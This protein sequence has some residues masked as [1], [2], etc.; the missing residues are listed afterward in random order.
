MTVTFDETVF[1]IN[2]DTPRCCYSFPAIY[3][4]FNYGTA[5]P[6]DRLACKTCGT[7]YEL[8]QNGN[9]QWVK[10]GKLASGENKA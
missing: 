6:G 8:K 5:R 9:W 2:R 1:E 7:L 4:D 3:L 10:V